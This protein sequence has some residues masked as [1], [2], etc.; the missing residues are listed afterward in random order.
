MFL[1]EITAPEDSGSATTDR[2]T[3]QVEELLGSQS[4][5]KG[6]FTTLGEG[7]PRVYYNVF[8][9]DRSANVAAILVMLR[10]YDNEATPALI[11]KLRQKSEGIGNAH[12]EFH[13]FQ[14]GPPLAAPIEVRVIG[15]NLVQSTRAT[16]A[17]ETALRATPGVRNINNPAGQHRMDVKAT[18]DE[19]KLAALGLGRTESQQLVRLVFSGLEACKIHDEN[20]VERTVRVCLPS[21]ERNDLGDWG[22]PLVPA[23]R[24]GLVPLKEV[25]RFEP[26]RSPTLLERRNGERVLTVSAQVEKGFN[27][28]QVTDDLRRRVSDLSLPSSCR[29]ELGGE[30]ESRKESFGGL[31]DAVLI[32]VFGI[33]AVLVLEFRTFRG[34][35]IVASV[36]PLGIVG[37]L[38]G[39]WLAGYSLS[40]MAAIGFIALIGI[41]IKNSILLVDLTNQMRLK[42]VGLDEA[43]ARAGE[44]RFLPV[45]LTTLTALGALLP[46][47]LQRSALFSPLAT[48]II[49]GSLSSLLLSRL[50]TP[51]LYRIL[52]PRI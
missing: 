23:G 51:V 18:L 21:A 47:A 26:L 33:L 27:I 12:I 17:I 2:I 13:E 6:F 50:V 42:G 15:D 1:V 28:A 38:L 46:L 29:W 24:T 20:G 10:T 16:A 34:T 25:A 5:V 9:A 49:G 32:A 22:K 40:F 8:P 43:I 7:N 39:L 4:E 14:N 30:W 44:I 37:G 52:P 31:G 35:L 48:V 11:E 3:R 19:G 45:A 41:E 36:I